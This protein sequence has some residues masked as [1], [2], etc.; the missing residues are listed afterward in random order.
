[1]SAFLQP[2]MLWGL[3]AAAVPILIHLLA[4]RRFRTVKWAAM[5]FLRAAF[6]KNQ[7]R[8]RLE[9]LL[10]LIIRT[11]LLIL[12]VTALAR[13]FLSGA[14]AQA[15]APQATR[16]TI[17]LD[18]SY[19]MGFN[20]GVTT[21]FARAVS[22]ATK[23]ATTL[24]AEDSVTLY[25]SSDNFAGAR[26]GTPRAILRESHEPEKV[27]GVLGRLRVSTGRCDLTEVLARVA[28]E[29]D[30]KQVGQRV[31]L[32]TDMQRTSWEA[33]AAEG[34]AD[35]MTAT[36]RTL[37]DLLT[38]LIEVKGVTFSLIDVGAT[39]PANAAVLELGPSKRHPLVEKNPEA[40]RARLA[41]Y[42]SAPVEADVAFSVDGEH[43]GSTRVSLPGAPAAGR[44]G[45]GVAEFA[46]PD[47]PAGHHSF[48]AAIPTDGLTVDDRRRFT[49]EVRE[50][51]RILAVDGDP[52]PDDGSRPEVHYLR[53]AIAPLD[54][55]IELEDVDYLGFLTRDLSTFDLV[56]L[57]NL[58]RVRDDRVRALTEFLDRG[59]ALTI[60]L[61][62]RVDPVLLN[63]SLGPE[64][65]GL[66]P[67]TLAEEPVVVERRGS[68]TKFDLENAA[69]HPMFTEIL[70]PKADPE[71]FWNQLSPRVWGYYPVTID[72][73]DPAVSVLLTLTDPDRSPVL[74]ER[75]V[76]RGRVLLTTT[77]ADLA[78]SSFPAGIIVPFMHEMVFYM[79][80]RDSTRSNLAPFGTFERELPP[81]VVTVTVTTPD[82]GRVKVT[83]I[84]PKEGKGAEGK[85][86]RVE[87]RDTEEPGTYRVEYSVRGESAIDAATRQRSELFSV[88]VDA[89]ESD[90]RRIG[91]DEVEARYAGIP[92]NYAQSFSGGTEAEDRAPEG[93]IFK[94]LL[95]AV[96]GL[97]FLETFLAR[98][99]GDYAARRREV[100]P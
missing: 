52:K 31:V 46:F 55:R 84:L 70:G 44:P 89:K 43:K 83:P 92:L 17:I 71:G 79:T 30:T 57:A 38:D 15:V 8:L 11:A 14:V 68:T 21:P 67:A 3:S 40:F 1:M 41:N 98:R 56:I 85:A 35:E 6:K 33:A 42:G 78:W 87:F 80:A 2:W 66:L 45:I 65:A 26:P 29:I 27:R 50:R 64:G 51:I 9:N 4:R 100:R 23:I 19:S 22:E 77:A 82:G 95:L 93:E 5:E 28:D 13:P 7:R 61:G 25:L 60:F 58:E 74:L 20:E 12:L 69:E 32:L 94:A 63:R 59:G 49:A 91:R 97:L 99:F 37:R 88:N 81:R 34:G 10:L 18:N 47:V 39:K 54:D 53:K 90:P 16:Y 62:D 76:G 24:G 73:E 86:P 96:L 48:E 75:K 36:A 72:P